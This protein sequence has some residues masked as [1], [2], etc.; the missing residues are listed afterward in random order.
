MQKTSAFSKFMACRHGQ[1]EEVEPLR[2]RG[3]V[4]FHNF[5]RRLFW[6]APYFNDPFKAE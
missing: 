3:R 1:G 2:T 6:T 5:V 4:N